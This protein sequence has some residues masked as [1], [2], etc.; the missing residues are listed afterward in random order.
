MNTIMNRSVIVFLFFAILLYSCN[1]GPSKQEMRVLESS[2]AKQVYIT[3]IDKNYSQYFNNFIDIYNE[4]LENK[5]SEIL[6][7]TDYLS[8]YS[9][10]RSEKK[11]EELNRQINVFN[12]DNSDEYRLLKMDLEEKDI[13]LI[14]EAIKTLSEYSPGSFDEIESNKLK[15]LKGSYIFN[16]YIIDLEEY[17]MHFQKFFD[18]NVYEDIENVINNKINR[19]EQL[20]LAFEIGRASCRERV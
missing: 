19:S 20:I 15:R 13:S 1:S 11:I 12:I 14:K 7:N 8:S 6:H 2:V 3:N 5:E 18:G 16:Y 10:W 17:Y 9:V 4:Y